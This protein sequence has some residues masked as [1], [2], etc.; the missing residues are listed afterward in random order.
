VDQG[1]ITQLLERWSH[2]EVDSFDAP[3]LTYALRR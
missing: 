2:G 1:Q 3:S